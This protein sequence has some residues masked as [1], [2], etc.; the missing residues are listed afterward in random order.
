QVF[1]K[2]KLARNELEKLQAQASGVLLLSDEQQQAL[3]QSLQALTDEERLQ[4][5]EQSRLQAAQQWL[6]RQQEL[7]AEASQAQVRLQDAQ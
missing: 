4:L 3:Q 1:E 5:S 6:L 7:S 2:H